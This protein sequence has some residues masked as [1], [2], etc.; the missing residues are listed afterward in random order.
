MTLRLQSFFAGLLAVLTAALLALGAAQAKPASGGYQLFE[1]VALEHQHAIQLASLGNFDYHAKVASECCN[2]P[3]KG[4]ETPGISPSQIQRNKIAGDRASDEI[5][6]QHPNSQREVI[7]RTTNGPR[8][9][10]V[11]TEDGGAIESKVGRTSADSTTMRQVNKDRE[12]LEN[13][14]VTSVTWEFR[15]SAQ[16]GRVG[17]TPR[18]QAE[19]ET[20]GIEIRI[21]D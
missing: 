7:L 6:L 18:L 10:D 11:L 13:G 17:P 4:P 9:V 15:R 14:D 16:T 1:P 5:A 20:A 21:I 8:R 2:A 3:N 12:L 19:L